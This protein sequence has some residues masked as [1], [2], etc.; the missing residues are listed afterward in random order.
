MLI[1]KTIALLPETPKTIPI[2]P[3][4]LRHKSNLISEACKR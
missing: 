1:L 4:T 3:P 2:L